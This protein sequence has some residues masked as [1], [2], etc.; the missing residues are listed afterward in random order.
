MLPSC[1]CRLERAAAQDCRQKRRQNPT[2]TAMRISTHKLEGITNHCSTENTS[3]GASP[4]CLNV[5]HKRRI[6]GELAQTEIGAWR[7]VWS[8]P[9]HQERV[10][11]TLLRINARPRPNVCE[12]DEEAKAT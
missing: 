9:R 6:I 3:W 12:P 2:V 8:E 11:L 10:Q 5:Y 1:D 4:R 7:V